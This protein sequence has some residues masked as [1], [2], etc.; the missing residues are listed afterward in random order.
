[1]FLVR[2]S[3][4]FINFEVIISLNLLVFTSGKLSR[5]ISKDSGSISDLGISKCIFRITFRRL[6]VID[7]IVINL[8]GVDG[9]SKV[10]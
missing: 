9:I 8:F 6:A 4:L 10:S 3:L 1:M 5:G 2:E 7:L